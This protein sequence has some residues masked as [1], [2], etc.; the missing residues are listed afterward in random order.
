MFR[1]DRHVD[2]IGG[3]IVLY[4]KDVLH[5]IEYHTK[6]QYGEHVWCRV[7]NLLIGVC[8]RSVTDLL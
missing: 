7:G 1:K 4:V 2:N 3:G 6:T 8:Y 5:P